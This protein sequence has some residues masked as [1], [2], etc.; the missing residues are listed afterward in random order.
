MIPGWICWAGDAFVG[1]RAV[2]PSLGKRALQKKV[3]SLSVNVA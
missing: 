2:G 1:R 3:P